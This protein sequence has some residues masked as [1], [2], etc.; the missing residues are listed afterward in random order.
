MAQAPGSNLV[1][2]KVQ[3]CMR[4]IRRPSRFQSEIARRILNGC[5]GV[6]C[7]AVITS[8]TL[9]AADIDVNRVDDY[10]VG[11]LRQGMSSVVSGD[12]LVFQPILDGTTLSNTGPILNLNVP[13]TLLDSN[14]ITITDSHGFTLSAPLTVDWAGVL[15]LDG[16]LSNGTANGS[17]FKTGLGT[18]VLSSVNTFSGGVTADGGTLQVTNSN[19]LGTGTLTIKNTVGTPTLKLGDGL[20]LANSIALQSTLNIDSSAGTSNT[21]SGV[22]SGAAAIDGLNTIGTG[23]LILSGT[24]TFIGGVHVTDASTIGVQNS[25]ALG[26][27][28]LTNDSALTLN[29]KSGITVANTVTLGNELIT[30]VD[31]GTVTMS[32]AIGESAVSQ[33][34]K[35]GAGTLI[36]TGANTYTGGTIVSQGTLQGNSTSLTGN[37]TN[38]AS[39]IFNQPGTGTYA[40][41]IT[42]TG[43]LTKNGNGTLIFSGNDAL[44]TTL[45]VNAGELQVTGTIGGPVNVASAAASLTGTGSVGDVTNSGYVQPGTA[46]IGD[47]TVNGAFTQTSSGTTEIKTNSAGN[48]PG[49]NNDHL[50]ITGQATLGGTLS[51]VAVGGGVFNPATQYTILNATGGVTGQYA[52]ASSTLPAYGVVV[53]Y[54]AN[55]V[56]FHLQPTTSLFA[57]ALTENQVAVGTALDAL[58]L[59]TS[60]SLYTMINQLG[61]Q[62]PADQRLAM[63]QL[64]GS[65]Y[66]NLQ[67]IGL[68]IGDQFQQ[69]VTSALVTNTVFLTGENECVPSQPAPYGMGRGWIQGFGV[70]GNLRGD[71]NAGG[72]NYNQGG[73][74]VGVDGGIDET[75]RMGVAGGSSYVNY[76]DD[77]SAR[78]QVTSYQIGAY[79]IKHDDFLYMLGTVNYGY[80]DNSTNRTL[81]AGGLNQSLHANFAGNQVGASLESGIFLLSVGPIQVQP[82]VGLQYLYLCQQGFSESGGVAGLTVETARANSLRANMGARF[83]LN[84]WTGRN[85][86]VFTTFSHVR[87]AQECLDNDRL[88]NASF[89]GAPAGGAFT[90]HGTRI[91]PCYGIAGQGLEVRFSELWSLQ[92]SVDVMTGEQLTVTSGSITSMMRW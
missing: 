15:T 66:G 7:S 68:Q 79:G 42:G 83:A 5:F 51:V 56:T 35:T 81:D 69:K 58:S 8:S 86:T 80:N 62:S 20:T 78:G 14:T 46:S 73:G 65:V 16:V 19:A 92:G 17:L 87:Y 34:T 25:A 84:P 72:A 39:L 44:T 2:T 4:H 32:G 90:T 9:H 54:N 53:T 10:G 38:N 60:G 47:L 59:T 67:T 40:G 21:L 74:L 6:L 50:T 85:G 27:G 22:I 89:N 36:L 18:L 37:I 76:C 49:V 63:D 26:T 13:A 41:T 29:L 23:T 57:A 91:G 77:S 88:V 1:M 43:T 3:F 30:N 75:G 33:L 12:R 64:S 48:V 61:I 82:L 24:N 28:T 52:Q 70:N 31:S 11:S 71:G 45:Q 55:D